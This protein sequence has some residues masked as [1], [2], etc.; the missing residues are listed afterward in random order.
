M[1]DC[2]VVNVDSYQCMSTF[3]THFDECRL[4]LQIPGF[5]VIVDI[6]INY[7]VNVG[8]QIKIMKL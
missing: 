7:L 8:I 1:Y 5:L 6:H 2:L 3:T 4:F